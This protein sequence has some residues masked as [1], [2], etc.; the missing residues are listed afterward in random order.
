MYIPHIIGNK[1]LLKYDRTWENL[2]KH[3]E[4]KGCVILKSQFLA[5]AATVTL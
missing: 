1:T 2:L 3:Y 5:R 4:E